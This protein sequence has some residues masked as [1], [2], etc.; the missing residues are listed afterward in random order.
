MHRHFEEQLEELR[1]KLLRL[2]GL[3]EDAIGRSVR[4][5]VERD[6]ELAEAVVTGDDELDRLEVEIDRICTGL[7][8]LQQP[9]AGDLRFIT[10]A[11]KITTDLERIGDLAVNV[12]ERA[13]EL[14]REP[15]LTPDIDIPLMAH[16]ATKMVHGAIEAFVRREA[17]AARAL[18]ARDDELDS[19]MV[20][21]F[22]ELLSFMIEDPRTITRA[23]RLVFIAKY[24][25][26]MGD[27]AT[28]ICEQVVF[29]VEGDIIKHPAVSAEPGES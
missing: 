3:V 17:A 22:R 21:V 6:S 28:N 23:L 12:C 26:R 20:Q 7:L 24:F 2:A 11:M 18:I 5:L 25:E 15:P 27:Q 13:I 29:M 4:A 14:N 16:R 9:M 8:A 10:T 19:L 1:R